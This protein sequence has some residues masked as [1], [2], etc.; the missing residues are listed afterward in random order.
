MNLSIT[1]TDLFRATPEELFF[2]GD[3][4][5]MVPN[6]PLKVLVPPDI[7]NYLEPA[8]PE[9]THI[10]AFCVN[11]LLAVKPPLLVIVTDLKKVPNE[12]KKF[13]SSGK[14]WLASSSSG[15]MD[16]HV[17]LGWAINFVNWLVHYRTTLSSSV[18]SKSALLVLDGH[19]SRECPAA[20]YLFAAANIKCVI[21]PSHCHHMLQ[22]F[23]EALA[24]PLKRRFTNLFND[25]IKNKNYTIENNSAAT[26]RN[27]IVHALVEAWDAVCVQ[28]NVSAG[29]TQ[30]GIN[31]VNPG[32]VRA[33]PYV[34]DFT[35]EERAVF[36]R[37]MERMR[38]RVSTSN[39]CITETDKI[40][41]IRNAM[42]NRPE[43]NIIKQEF[44][45]PQGADV[46]VAYFY[47]SHA[48]ITSINNGSSHWLSPIYPFL[49]NRYPE[50]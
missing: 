49:T 36:Q 2:V 37:H 42:N 45:V 47:F 4:T 38:N 31:P 40:A 11:S 23:D 3:E 18:A 35:P 17:F 9:P 33:S 44:V 27:V 43:W 16:R 28:C 12:L 48:L 14:I 19:V 29:A 34:R 5:M 30:V 15:W 32:V 7:L 46:N 41:E 10:T 8:P 1:S 26:L 6:K 24:S 50:L 21:L 20:L 39:S 22:L 13:V 25:Y